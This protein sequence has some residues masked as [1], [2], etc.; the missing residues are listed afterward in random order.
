MEAMVPRELLFTVKET[1]RVLRVSERTIWKMIA[2][3][4]L[5]CLHPKGLDVVRIPRRALVA[6]LGKGVLDEVAD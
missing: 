5:R 3:G 4:R 6:V 2:D 1:A